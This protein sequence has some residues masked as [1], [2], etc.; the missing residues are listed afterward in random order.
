MAS[1]LVMCLASKTQR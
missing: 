1:I